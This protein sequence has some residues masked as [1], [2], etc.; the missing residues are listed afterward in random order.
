MPA[1]V[2]FL[3][4]HRSKLVDIDV[5]ERHLDTR[6]LWLGRLLR[7]LENLKG[8]H[9]VDLLLSPTCCHYSSIYNLFIALRLLWVPLPSHVGLRRVH[10]LLGHAGA[11][12]M[13]C[14]Q[15]LTYLLYVLACVCIQPCGRITLLGIVLE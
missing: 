5:I 10:G 1:P 9:F 14:V 8:L 13:L 11:S 4:I 15:N 6:K 3:N 7:C 2:I 12:N